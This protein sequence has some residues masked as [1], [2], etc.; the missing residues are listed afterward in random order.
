MYLV[1]RGGENEEGG[2]TGGSDWSQQKKQI[3]KIRDLNELGRF[4]QTCTI[5]QKG[6]QCRI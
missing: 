5:C 2:E 1:N 3:G 6:E 4:A